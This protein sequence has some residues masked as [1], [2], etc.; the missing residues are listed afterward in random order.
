MVFNFSLTQKL[1]PFFF[2][3]ARGRALFLEFFLPH[4]KRSS[5]FGRVQKQSVFDIQSDYSINKLFIDRHSARKEKTD[6][7]I[8]CLNKGHIPL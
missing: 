6:R 7:V 4:R 2:F 8:F 1:S 3:F 5:Y